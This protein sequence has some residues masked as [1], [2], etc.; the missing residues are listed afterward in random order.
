[1]GVSE[2]LA[3][4]LCMASPFIVVGIIVWVLTK[5]YGP[6]IISRGVNQQGGD[7][8]FIDSAMFLS[9]DDD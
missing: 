6:P 1:M 4:G 5:M 7:A 9:M 3:V 8:S 2:A